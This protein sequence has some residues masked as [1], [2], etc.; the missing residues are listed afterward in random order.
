MC[1][2]HARQTWKCCVSQALR[3]SYFSH[4][5]RASLLQLPALP[6]KKIPLSYQRLPVVGMN[7][8][9]QL[10]N[11][12]GSVERENRKTFVEKLRLSKEWQQNVKWNTEP[13]TGGPW[14]TDRLHVYGAGLLMDCWKLRWISTA[15]LVSP[16][17]PQIADVEGTSAVLWSNIPILQGRLRLRESKRVD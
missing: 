14:V 9:H 15:P 1:R 5:G 2:C 16:S 11:W 6:R 12:W 7:R 8:L 4:Q 13:S 17:D 10:H 3:A